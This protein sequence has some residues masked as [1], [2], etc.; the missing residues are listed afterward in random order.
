[1]R[2]VLLR[3]C[4]STNYLSEEPADAV[5][6]GPRTRLG[7]ANAA[8]DAEVAIRAL[9][10]AVAKGTMHVVALSL[11]KYLK[12]S[13]RPCCSYG[14][15]SIGALVSASGGFKRIGECNTTT[16]TV[17]VCVLPGGET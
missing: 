5:V 11:A 1:M 13:K 6:V 7:I 4:S 17:M 15:R 3:S 16:A 2:Q 10:T 12:H 14:D 8:A 9:P